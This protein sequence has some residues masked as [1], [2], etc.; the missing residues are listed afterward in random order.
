MYAAFRVGFRWVFG[1]I[2]NLR[3]RLVSS[4]DINIRAWHSS[5]DGFGCPC[6]LGPFGY[7]EIRK[8][9][10]RVVFFLAKRVCSTQSGLWR[11]CSV[12]R[13]RR[14]NLSS[15]PSR[16]GFRWL[17]DSSGICETTFWS[18]Q[19]PSTINI[20]HDMLPI[21]AIEGFCHALHG[22]CRLSLNSEAQ[23]GVCKLGRSADSRLCGAAED[24]KRANTTSYYACLRVGFSLGLVMRLSQ[25]RVL[26]DL[27]ITPHITIICV[28]PSERLDT[29]H[30]IVY[31]SLDAVMLELDSENNSGAAFQKKI[32][33]SLLGSLHDLSL[34]FGATSLVKQCHGLIARS[35]K[36]IHC[37]LSHLWSFIEGH[38]QKDV[39]L[40]VADSHTGNHREDDFRSLGGE[41]FKPNRRHKDEAII[42]AQFDFKISIKEVS[43]RL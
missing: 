17:F 36:V 32:P 20:R 23:L 25:C 13:A 10:S 34:R 42:F 39:G 15:V 41:A 28:S 31:L 21:M 43:G 37:G 19:A 27:L 22:A 1:L 30:G 26:D 14:Q 5:H 6:I 11:V 3:Q 29:I 16:V 35:H 8:L 38:A 24:V 2:G 12:T 40:R 9:Y 7:P 4:P 33:E 18:V